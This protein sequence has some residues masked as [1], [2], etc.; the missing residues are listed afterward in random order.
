MRLSK[1]RLFAPQTLI[2]LSLITLAKKTGFSLEEITAMMG[3]D[4]Q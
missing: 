2:H 1:R 3:R 4:S